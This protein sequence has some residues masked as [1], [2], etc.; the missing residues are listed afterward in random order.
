VIEIE[1]PTNAEQCD[2][3][4]QPTR[5]SVTV[6]LPLPLTAAVIVTVEAAMW[7]IGPPPLLVAAATS[8]GA[9]GFVKGANADPRDGCAATGAGTVAAARCVG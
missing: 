2:W 3:P 4:L 6:A 8:V 1:S 7:A 9:G 5:L